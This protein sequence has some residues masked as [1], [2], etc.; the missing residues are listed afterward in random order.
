MSITTEAV[1]MLFLLRATWLVTM[2][3][4][5][6]V[7]YD[8]RDKPATTTHDDE[9]PDTELEECGPKSRQTQGV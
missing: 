4:H 8:K 6:F 5:L 2:P 1:T 7:P 9:T 3:K